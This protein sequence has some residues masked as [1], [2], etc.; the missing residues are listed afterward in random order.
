MKANSGHMD[1]R[2][3]MSQPQSFGGPQ[4]RGARWD[5]KPAGHAPR[6]ADSSTKASASQR[7]PETRRSYNLVRRMRTRELKLN[8][9]VLEAELR[10]AAD[11]KVHFERKVLSDMRVRLKLMRA[12]KTARD[13]RDLGRG[14]EIPG[15]SAFSLGA[16]A[17]IRV[18]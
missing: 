6:S 1:I 4:I 9:A 11:G 16:R 10:G 12:E 13:L 5:G 3:S 14:R 7:H 15:L 2:H 17:S 18:S 8:I